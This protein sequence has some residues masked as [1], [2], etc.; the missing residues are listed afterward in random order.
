MQTVHFSQKLFVNGALLLCSDNPIRVRMG[1]QGTAYRLAT[2]KGHSKMFT[3]L[4]QY[5]A[6]DVASCVGNE[7]SSA[8]HEKWEKY[9]RSLIL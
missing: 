2:I 3:F 5:N 9:Q 8:A 4:E 6:K 1:N 7:I